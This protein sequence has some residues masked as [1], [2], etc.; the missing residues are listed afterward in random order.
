[1]QEKDKYLEKTKI[2]IFILFLCFSN[3]LIAENKKSEILDYNNS[4]KNS[5]A[6][7]LQTDGETIEEGEVFIGEKRIRLEYQSPKRLTIVLTPKKGMYVNHALK[8]TQY[9]NTKK[10]FVDIFL[11]ILTGKNFYEES[12]MAFS[13]QNILIKNDLLISDT[14]YKT[15]II[16]ENDPIKLR[17]IKIKE[18][19][20]EIEIGFYN[21]NNLRT[22]DVR[23][24]SLINPYLDQ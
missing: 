12:F 1:M 4:L 15:E 11:K 18:E 23:F 17:K 19:D 5:S 3:N 21:H 6:L 8:E 10:S 22:L 13:E 7:F 14:L 2:I 9:F 20:R 24:F 16:Y